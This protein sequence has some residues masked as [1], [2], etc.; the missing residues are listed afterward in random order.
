MAS[1]PRTTRPIKKIRI[2]P[3]DNGQPHISSHIFASSHLEPIRWN[4]VSLRAVFI[5]VLA[6]HS[7]A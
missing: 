7:A 4:I 2:D 1:E 5:V 3:D 6:C